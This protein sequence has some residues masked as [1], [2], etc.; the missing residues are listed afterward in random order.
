M[1]KS[2]ADAFEEWKA[3]DRY[4]IGDDIGW[5]FADSREVPCESIAESAF[6]TEVSTSDQPKK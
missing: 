6:L 5:E 3:D 1:P 2:F 4:K